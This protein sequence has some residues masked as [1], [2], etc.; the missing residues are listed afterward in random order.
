MS[1]PKK[2]NLTLMSK[3]E[4]AKE[5]KSLLVESGVKSLSEYGYPNV[6]KENILTDYVFAAFFKSMLRDNLGKMYPEAQQ[7]AHGLIDQLEQ[8][9][10]DDTY[11]A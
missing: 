5:I 11:K 1:A 7:S 10:F 6:S 3:D 8:V 2:K 4:R 9:K